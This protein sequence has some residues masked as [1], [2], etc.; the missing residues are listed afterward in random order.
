M[1]D[2]IDIDALISKF[3]SGEATPDEAILLEDWKHKDML[4][5]LYY[6]DCENAF[7]AIN[8]T[9]S[10]YSVIDT[11]AAWEKVKPQLS[12]SKPKAVI[13]KIMYYQIA[14]SLAIVIGVS[15]AVYFML[16]DQPVEN[17]SFMTH[18]KSRAVE[19][20]DG[21]C[22]II[23]PNSVLTPDKGYGKHN[24]LLYLKGSAYFSVVHKDKLPL[25]VDA[26]KVFIKDIGTQYNIIAHAGSDSLYVHVDE[27]EVSLYDE[28][29]AEAR[30]KGAESAF[31]IKSQ[32]KISM[33]VTDEVI[34]SQMQDTINLNFVNTK[35]IDVI[36]TLNTKYKTTIILEKKSLEN[37]TIT[38]KFYNE[39]IET[40]LS[41][42]AET[43]GVTYEKNKEGFI[44]KG[45]KC[46][47]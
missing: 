21:T 39:K 1:T 32:K 24:R 16:R 29:G 34:R 6:T 47:H 31:Y 15:T 26:G 2:L 22:V 8:G 41:I 17:H 7:N 4:N 28:T 3:L 11:K 12:P 18:E 10:N 42:I 20:S 38:S 33:N 37:C 9:E 5:Q 46:N 25:I 45:E 44:I 13:R 27:G 40:V 36:K 23:A 14:A 19:L 43:L 35:L 30:I